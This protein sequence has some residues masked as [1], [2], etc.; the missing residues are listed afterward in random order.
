MKILFYYRGAESFGIESISAVLKKGGHQTELIYD[1]GFDDT[2]YFKAGIFNVLNVNK[3]LIQEAKAFDPDLIAFGAITNLYPYVKTIARQLKKELN[4]PHIIGNIHA[5]SIPDYVIK[6]D[7]FDMVCTGEGEEAMLELANKMEA[8]EDYSNIANIWVKKDGAVIRSKDRPLIMDL[9]TIPFPD[10]DLFYKKGAFWKSVQAVTSRGCPYHCTFCVN[11]IYYKKYDGKFLRRRRVDSVIEEVRI[12]KKKYKPS[13]IH[14]MD[15]VFTASGEWMEEFTEK[16][17]REIG[18]KFLVNVYPSTINKHMARLLRDAGCELACMGVQSANEEYRRKMLQRNESNAKVV[19]AATL[20][21]EVGIRLSTEFIFGMPDD[22]PEDSW[23]AVLLNDKIKP[24]STSSFVFYP[25]P[26][27]ALAE[28]AK[29]HGYLDENAE[30]M[31]NEGNGSYHTTLFLKN[32]KKD[33][34][35]NISYLAP[36]FLW[37]PTWVSRKFLRKLCDMKSTLL[38]RWV[39]VLIIPLHNPNHFMEKLFNYIRMFVYYIASRPGKPAARFT[40]SNGLP[41]NGVQARPRRHQQGSYP[42]PATSL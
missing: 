33:F 12:Y 4:V 20:L 26:K 41:E 34:L 5:A 9:D 27:T 32:P 17:S 1:P 38:H 21:R 31:V 2:F 18:I 16:Y 36:L 11:N 14:F 23:N 40:Q 35:M 10:K 24:T 15:D 6:E 13:I 29:K 39:A 28:Y 37:M 42:S 7:C 30:T 19:E 25:F 8:G 3:K 22:S